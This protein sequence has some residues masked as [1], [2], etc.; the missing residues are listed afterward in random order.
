MNRPQV[1]VPHS[2]NRP[3]RV[4]LTMLPCL[5][6][7]DV[8]SSA[9]LYRFLVIK[10]FVVELLQKAETAPHELC[11]FKAMQVVQTSRW[12]RGGFDF[13]TL[14]A[15]NI[16][17]SHRHTHKDSPHTIKWWFNYYLANIS[18]VNETLKNKE[19]CSLDFPI[20]ACLPFYV[21]HLITCLI[22]L[23]K[24]LKYLFWNKSGRFHTVARNRAK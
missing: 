21:F 3:A 10:V 23:L 20:G 4:V 2:L 19:C 1:Q 22:L 14:I 5:F 15:I 12:H 8:S 13:C 9:L 17:S 7:D 11:L 6:H 16:Y 24:Y 18:S